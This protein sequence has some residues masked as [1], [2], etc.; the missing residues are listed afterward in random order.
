MSHIS[1]TRKLAAAG[2]ILVAKLT[3]QVNRVGEYL[4]NAAAMRADYYWDSGPT[5]IEAC[6]SCGGGGTVDDGGCPAS[7]G[8]GLEYE[9]MTLADVLEGNSDIEWFAEDE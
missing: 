9:S 8:N 6:W 3:K 4:S 5:V 7:C 1:I 2:C